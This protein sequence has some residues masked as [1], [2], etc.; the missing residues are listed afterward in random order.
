MA[1]SIVTAGRTIT[2]LV[3]FTASG[4][5]TLSP[6]QYRIEEE[7][8]IREG[9]LL[10]DLGLRDTNQVVFVSF[11]NSDGSH[12]DPSDAVISRM[13][14]AHIPARK[15]S[16]STTDE[17]GFVVDKVTG[18]RGVI[19]YAGVVRWLRNSKVE[20]ISGITCARLGGGFSEFIM[21]KEDGKWI[22][23]R[24]KRTITI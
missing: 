20:V 1:L 10:E 9:V 2:L 18:K 12:I 24:T 15:A 22:R 17:H 13:H 21:K 4:C 3:L 19:H 7:A 14:A 16:E 5:M 11:F 8:R 6:R 23:T